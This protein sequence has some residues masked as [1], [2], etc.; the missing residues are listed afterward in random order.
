LLVAC[1]KNKSVPASAPEKATLVFPGKDQTCT[2]G[3]TVNA[4][5]SKI[6]FKW[7][8]AEHADKYEIVVINLLNKQKVTESTTNTQFEFTLARNTP[9][10]W[11]VTSMSSKTDAFTGSEIWKFY[12][13]GQGMLS[14]APFPAEILSP[15]NGTSIVAVN[16]KIILS[17]SGSDVDNDI[18]NYDV[19]LGQNSNPGLLTEKLTQPLLNDVTVV[20]GN[21]YWR[22]VTRDQQGNTSDSGLQNFVVK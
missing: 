5:S 3:T 17:W 14:Y 15:L 12:N 10:S 8:A 19:Y 16:G 6:L 2:E 11:S 1:K 7:N 20:K 9:Y 4:A 13:A 18:L 21:Y 22:I